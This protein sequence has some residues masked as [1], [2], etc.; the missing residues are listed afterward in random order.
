[1]KENWR[2]RF[3]VTTESSG[4]LGLGNNLNEEF[5]QQMHEPGTLHGDA[6][7]KFI[8]EHQMHQDTQ[9]ADQRCL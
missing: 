2:I 8:Q 1:M 6:C 7:V 3:P 4:M 9:E 5:T